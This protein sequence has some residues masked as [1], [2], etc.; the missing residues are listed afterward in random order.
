MGIHEIGTVITIIFLNVWHI[1]QG[2]TEWL[3]NST[4]EKNTKV[5]SSLVYSHSFSSHHFLTYRNELLQLVR[6]C[7][8]YQAVT[9]EIYR[10][11]QQLVSNS[12]Y[13]LQPLKVYQNYTVKPRLSRFLEYPDFFSGPNLVMNIY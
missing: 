3:S 10:L 6:Q 4:E 8:P 11:K 5:I 12:S 7:S 13:C 1:N 2:D 9:G